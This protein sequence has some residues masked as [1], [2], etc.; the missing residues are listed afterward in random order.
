MYLK[1]DISGGYIHIQRRLSDINITDK[2]KSTLVLAR[3]E[4]HN[5]DPATID[6]RFSADIICTTLYIQLVEMVE[7]EGLEFFLT[8]GVRFLI[9]L[10]R[11]KGEK[12]V[13]C[14]YQNK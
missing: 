1:G 6:K 13:G 7:S 9:Y 8:S 10:I 12:H 11:H 2:M 5:K 4:F 3:R 14:L